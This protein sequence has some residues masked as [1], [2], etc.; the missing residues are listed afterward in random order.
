MAVEGAFGSVLQEEQFHDLLAIW[1]LS[2][3]DDNPIMT[4][5]GIHLRLEMPEADVRALV[6]KYRELFRPGVPSGPLEEWKTKMRQGQS[7]PIWLNGKSG[8][9]REAAIAALG[10]GDCFRSQFRAQAGASQS[11]LAVL[12]WGVCH[13]ERLR[14][15]L[16]EERDFRQRVLELGDRLAQVQRDQL[17]ARIGQWVTALCALLAAIAGIVA[18]LVKR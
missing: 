3:N 2:S 9:E 11:S 6:R 4:Y 10:P 15:A 5:Q 13:I 17:Q 7:N 1:V 16:T 8:A 12:E 14:R 18:A